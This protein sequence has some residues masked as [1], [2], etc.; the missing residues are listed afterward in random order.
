V[1]FR[2]MRSHL[3]IVLTISVGLVM[4]CNNDIEV[5]P[6][7]D[8]DAQWLEDIQIIEDYITANGYSYDTTTNGVRYTIL[9]SGSGNSVNPNDIVGFHYI[10]RLTT[11]TLFRTS[12]DTVLF[13]NGAGDSSRSYPPIH[14]TYSTSGWNIPSIYSSYYDFETGYREGVSKVIGLMKEGGHAKLMI[15]SGLAYQQFDPTTFG[16]IPPYSVLVF[17]IFFVSTE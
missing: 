2:N 4:S 5:E 17:D 14:Y 3:L 10:G 1:H 8:T 15:P 16:I 11:D 9:D 13:N 7:V 6:T 12:V